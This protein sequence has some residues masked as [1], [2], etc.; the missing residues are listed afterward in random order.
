MT[1]MRR[2]PVFSFV[3][4]GLAAASLAGIVLVVLGAAGLRPA[5]GIM[6]SL[7]TVAVATV[8]VAWMGRWHFDPAWIRA[9][10]AAAAIIGLG[11]DPFFANPGIGVTQG[12]A[13]GAGLVI[14]VAGTRSLAPPLRPVPAWLISVGL[15]ALAFALVRIVV[16]GGGFG[17][18]ESAYALKGRAWI[19]GTP[20][21]GWEIHRG[22]VQSALAAAVLP[23]TSSEAV[24]R[25]VSVVLSVGT[26]VTVWWLG[27]TVRSRRVGVMAAAVFVTSPSYLRRGAEFLTDV[28]STGLLLVVTVLW[29]RWLTDPKPRNSMLWWAVVVATFAFYWRYQAVLSLGLLV[30]GALVIFWSRIRSDLAAVVRAALFAVV[31]LIPHVIYAMAETGRPWGILTRTGDAA[32]RAYLG[33]G[34]V[35]YATDFPDLLAGQIGAVAILFALAW[36][37]WRL[38]GAVRRRGLESTDR[39]ALYLAVPAIGQIVL[40]GLISHGE[41][42]FV[43]YPVSLLLVMAGLG[44]EDVRRRVSDEWFRVG[45]AGFVVAVVTLFGLNSDRADRGAET[46]AE[47]T[48]V[49]EE[50]ASTVLAQSGDGCGIVTTYTPQ[51]TWFSG[52]QTELPSLGEAVVELDRDLDRFL[53]LFDNGKRQPTGGVLA[54]Y[55]DLTAGEPI[56]VDDPVDSIGDARIWRIAD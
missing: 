52:C 45:V 29:W 4:G 10:G 56:V 44:V 31:L 46:L 37:V 12:A 47:S 17:H 3:A 53:V 9:G 43:F 49:L 1:V 26:V 5:P 34:L 35:D 41:P 23:F 42:R 18:D 36:L 11:A 27:T 55:L 33:E 51:L 50:T 16:G 6:I 22:W 32:G 24:M 13:L 30:P 39:L 40:L 8:V 25:L 19:Q 21:T 14:A 15:V 2:Q 38:I 48:V 28:P 20:E 7:A 54:G